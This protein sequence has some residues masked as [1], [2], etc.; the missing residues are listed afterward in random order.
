MKNLITKKI[1]ILVI[2][3][4]IFVAFSPIVNAELLE[5]GDPYEELE[6][7]SQRAGY[8]NSFLNTQLDSVVIRIINLALGFLGL[9]FVVLIIM[10]GFQWMTA[11]GN[12]DMVAKAKQR[13]LNAIIG[14]VIV[15]AAYGIAA[16]VINQVAGVTQT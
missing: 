12:S 3:F 1:T 14:L 9:F 16:F 8:D 13:L 11:G 10:S 5:S 7:F 2:I 4:F 6:N 15:L